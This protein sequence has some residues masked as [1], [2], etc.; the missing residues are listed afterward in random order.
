MGLKRPE[1]IDVVL[2]KLLAW[3]EANDWF[4]SRRA[5]YL[6]LLDSFG[7]SA[8]DTDRVDQIMYY[9]FAAGFVMDTDNHR[10]V[11]SRRTVRRIETFL[12][13]IER[14]N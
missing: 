2:R 14:Q 5:L 9:L 4:E 13:R 12:K 8:A 7:S 3:R 1:D 11:C 6:F 10:V